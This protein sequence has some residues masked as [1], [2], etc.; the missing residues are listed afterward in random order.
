VK[1]RG[2]GGCLLIVMALVLAAAAFG[3]LQ[4][5][6]GPG[7]AQSN[8]TVVVPQGASLGRAA[9]ELEKAGAIASARRFLIFARLF[10]GGGAIRAGEYRIPAHLSQS[11]ILKLM[12]GGRTLQR[13]VTVPEGTPAV[14]VHDTLMKAP[15]LGGPVAVPAEGSV[16]PDSYAYDRG[17]T[18]AAVLARMQAAMTRYLAAAWARRK[19]GIAVSSPQEALILASIVEKETGRP[20]ER[21][22]VA[23]VYSNRLRAGMPLQAD[24]TIIYPLTRGRPLGRRIRQSEV[25]ARN[26]YNTYSMTGLPAGP[27]ANPGRESID[28]VLDPAASAALY[29]VADGTGGH[30]FA[31]TLDQHNANVRKWYA[32]RRARGEM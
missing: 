23:A 9:A 27:I 6:G 21:R 32:I 25:R 26:A 2:R 10:G 24:P 18:R 28:A 30:V 20:A 8:L 3:V 7:P 19:P 29:F 14:L 13:M 11:D 31:D 5:W 22:L 12:Q 17:E 16:L 15:Q 4:L 1:W